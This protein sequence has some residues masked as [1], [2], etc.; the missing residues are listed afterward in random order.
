[1]RLFLNA[2][3]KEQLRLGA[4]F[5]ELQSSYTLAAHQVLDLEDRL[6]EMHRELRELRVDNSVLKAKLEIKNV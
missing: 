1:M 2:R 3:E 6:N 5:H 4:V